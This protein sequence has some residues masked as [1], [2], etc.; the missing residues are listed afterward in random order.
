MKDFIKKNFSV[1]LAFVLPVLLIVIVALSTYIPSMFVSTKYNF[2]YVSCDNLG[3]YYPYRCD[4]FLQKRYTVV[5]GKFAVN[6]VDMT[7][8]L[9]KGGVVDPKGQYDARIFLHDTEKNESREISLTEAQTLALSGLVTSPD[10]ITVSSN[11]SRNG[12]D[13]LFPFGGGSSSYGYYLTKGSG[14]RKINLINSS[15]QYYYQNNFQFVG[16]VLPGR[17]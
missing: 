13:F 7:K 17:N 3:G 15:D 14:K 5:D 9:E 6:P 11:Y 1:L 16:W 2:V 10:G 4:T 12:G 8:Y